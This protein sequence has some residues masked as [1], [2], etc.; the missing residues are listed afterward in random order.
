MRSRPNAL[1][2]EPGKQAAALA[3]PKG[4]AQVFAPYSAVVTFVEDYDNPD[5]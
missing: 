5:K 2:F 4:S 3:V 1:V